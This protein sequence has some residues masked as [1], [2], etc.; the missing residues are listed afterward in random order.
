MEN[1]TNSGFWSLGSKAN[2]N[3]VWTAERTV[4][5]W[6]LDLTEYDFVLVHRTSQS[7]STEFSDLFEKPADVRDSTVFR[8]KVTEQVVKLIG[9]R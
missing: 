3:D 4:P 6:A 7:L 5:E 9:L 8:V 2:E 1:E